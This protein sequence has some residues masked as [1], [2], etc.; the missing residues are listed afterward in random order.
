V[1]FA[2]TAVSHK[3]CAPWLYL[4]ASCA[5]VHTCCG[6]RVAHWSCSGGCDV[7]KHTSNLAKSMHRLWMCLGHVLG[8]LCL[9]A[10]S[11]ESQCDVPCTGPGGRVVSVAICRGLLQPQQRTA[12]SACR[13]WLVTWSCRRTYVVGS[14]VARAV[15]ARSCEP[16]E[17]GRRCSC[18]DC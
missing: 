7:C 1:C 10:A 18:T 16:C 12:M 15:V 11:L 8:H 5:P 6:P 3:V 4:L 13:R 9:L 14:V 17:R 2:S